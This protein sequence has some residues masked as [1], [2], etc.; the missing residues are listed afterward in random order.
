VLWLGEHIATLDRV[1]P[2]RLSDT[3]L[4]NFRRGR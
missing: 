4:K 3:A 2:G 1:V